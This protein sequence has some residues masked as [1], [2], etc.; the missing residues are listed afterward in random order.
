VFWV[1]VFVAAYILY[2][3]VEKPFAKLR[4]HIKSV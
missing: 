4:D 1:L 3:F 2:I